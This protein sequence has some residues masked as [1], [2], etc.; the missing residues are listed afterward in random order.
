MVHAKMNIEPKTEDDLP[1]LLNI[2]NL[3]RAANGSFPA[4]AYGMREFLAAIDGE[5]ILV[6]RIDKEIAGF[7][8]VWRAENFVHHLFVLPKHQ[9]KGIGKA[10]IS[11]CAHTFGLPLSLK[12]VAANTAACRFYEQSGWQPGS[13][14]VGP[15]GPY[16]RYQLIDHT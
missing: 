3:S 5:D 15:E 13:K 12:C 9:R 11:R 1:A 16:I 7:V 14:A 8:S 4:P 2:F 10:L 6:A